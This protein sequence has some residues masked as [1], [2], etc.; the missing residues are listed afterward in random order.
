MKTERHFS[1]PSM[2]NLLKVCRSSPRLLHSRRSALVVTEPV[3]GVRSFDRSFV[4][5][6][7]PEG[8]RWVRLS[9]NRRTLITVIRQIRAKSNG[10]DV[11]ILSD[12]LVIRGFSSHE[13]WNPGPLFVQAA[14]SSSQSASLP[15]S[16]LR[17]LEEI[18]HFR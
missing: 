6:P 8:S 2:D 10:W 9:G 14:P 15:A 1:C 18:V 12:Q 5:V 4:L 7:A 16:I 11:E 17:Q 3:G 13:A